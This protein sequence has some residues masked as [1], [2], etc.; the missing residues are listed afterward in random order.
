MSQSDSVS[1]EIAP[2]SAHTGHDSLFSLNAVPQTSQTR[3]AFIFTAPNPLGREF[4]RFG[5]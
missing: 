4:S 5:Y 1:G 2:R 3:L